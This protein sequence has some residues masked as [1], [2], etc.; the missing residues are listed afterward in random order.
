MDEI[1]DYENFKKNINY[2]L[3]IWLFAQN[4]IM[5]IIYN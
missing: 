5:D 4:F 2:W 1:E 3:K